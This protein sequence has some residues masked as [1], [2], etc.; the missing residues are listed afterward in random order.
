MCG[1]VGYVGAQGLRAAS[2]SRG[3]VVSSTAATT[4]PASPCTPGEGVEIVRAVGKLANLDSGAQ[5]ATRSRARPASATR[6]GPPTGGRARRTP[7][8]TSPGTSPSSTTASSRTTSQL[9]RE[10]EARG[11]PLLERHRHRDRRPPGRRGDEGRQRSAS[12]EAV[13]DRALKRVRGAY[14]I[15]VVCGTM[16]RTRSSSRADSSPLVLGVGDGEMLAASDIPAL[17]A[18]TRE[19]IFLQDGDIATLTRSGRRDHDARRRRRVDARRR[20]TSTGPRRRPRR[21][22]TSTSCSRRST[23]SRARSRTRCAGAWTSRGRRRRRRRSASRRRSRSRSRASTSS[24]AA[25]ALTRRWRGATGSSSS[26]SSRR[27]RDRRARCA[28]ASR[29]SPR[30]TSSSP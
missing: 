5:E 1:I 18:H 20:S 22:A 11:R 13:R 21:G 8:R 2:S 17:L 27:G 19:V 30:P 10:L 29:S 23:S 12:L 3:C 16:S 9:R 26:R 7:T 15:A 24:R 14:A 28:T 6:A 25:R 4:R